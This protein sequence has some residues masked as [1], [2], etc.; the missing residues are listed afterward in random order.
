MTGAFDGGC[1]EYD[2][3]NFGKLPL[4]NY[5]LSYFLNHVT[6]N[7][8]ND[9]S[10][11]SFTQTVDTAYLNFTVSTPNVIESYPMGNS[12]FLSPNPT[13]NKLN[14]QIKKIATTKLTY[15][16]LATD[17]RVLLQNTITSQPNFEIDVSTLPAGLYFLQLQDERQQWVKKFVKE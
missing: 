12:I 9:S 6:W 10:C 1:W 15:Q 3:V 5:H 8:P 7:N 17:G 11:N 13:T 14:L 2:S 4:G 16:I